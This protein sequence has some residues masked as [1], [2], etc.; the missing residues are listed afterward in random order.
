MQGMYNV[1]MKLMCLSW[2]NRNKKPLNIVVVLYFTNSV[3][4][5]KLPQ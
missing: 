3:L 4:L 1:T 5:S 2:M